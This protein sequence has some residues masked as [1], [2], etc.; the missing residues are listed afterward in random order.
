MF[1][2]DVSVDEEQVGPPVLTTVTLLLVHEQ[3]PQRAIPHVPEYRGVEE[4]NHGVHWY[5]PANQ[6]HYYTERH[7]IKSVAC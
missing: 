3:V 2:F 1:R 7:E 4:Y 6:V 5:Y